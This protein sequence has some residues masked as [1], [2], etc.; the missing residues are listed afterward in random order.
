M[1][2]EA[3]CACSAMHNRHTSGC[4]R[5]CCKWSEFRHAKNTKLCLGQ[6][7]D[8]IYFARRFEACTAKLDDQHATQLIPRAPDAMLVRAIFIPFGRVPIAERCSTLHWGLGGCT[9][10]N[11]IDK[12]NGADQKS[13][14]YLFHPQY[15]LGWLMVD[16]RQNTW[17]QSR[18]PC[19]P[20]VDRPVDRSVDRCIFIG[21]PPWTVNLFL[22]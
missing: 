2:L 17:L 16:E 21:F 19:G 18:G 14:Q 4:H 22:K 20:S 13:G 10:Q 6:S 1:L 11:L 12:S 7:V 3:P 8:G 9:L 5:S 15:W